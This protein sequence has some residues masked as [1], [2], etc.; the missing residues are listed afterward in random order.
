MPS[1]R[2]WGSRSATSPRATCA[3][4]PRR[5]RYPP[6]GWDIFI[7]HSGS[8]R[9]SAEQLYDRL[10]A[11]G[12]RVFLDARTLKPG[13]FWDLEIPRALATSQIIMVLI[14]SS[15]ESAHYLR[16][17]VAQVITRAR[18]TGSP[19]VVPVYID[20]SLPPGTVP[21]YGL[22]VVQAIDARAVGGLG[23]V[24]DQVMRLL[25]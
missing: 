5:R 21:P 7:A 6:G 1:S 16:A 24:A 4:P 2:R 17:E 3:R 20:G 25:A 19:R 11:R 10:A 22:G 13:D 8:D 12:H 9:A 23:A 18:A 14:A 15:Y